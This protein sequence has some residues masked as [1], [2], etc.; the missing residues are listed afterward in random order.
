M[1]IGVASVPLALAALRG[2]AP[3]ARRGT[4]TAAGY[5]FLVLSF[6]AATR[7]E[8]PELGAFG[9][10]GWA[11]I[12][13]IAGLLALL[14][15]ALAF[16]AAGAPARPSPRRWL[17]AAVLVH[18]GRHPRRPGA[19][20][21]G[22]DAPRHP[23]P[24]DA[25]RLRALGASRRIPGPRDLPPAA[26][27]RRRGAAPRPRRLVAA[28]A[29]ARGRGV[30]GHLAPSPAGPGS[31]LDERRRRGAAGR[32]PAGALRPRSRSAGAAGGH[33][34]LG[35]RLS[36]LARR[37]RGAGGAGARVLRD[38]RCRRPAALAASR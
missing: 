2:D 26:A 9:P 33:G 36:D 16:R 18:D 13:D 23:L 29:R 20:V 31:P 1:V 5:L 32:G 37:G 14:V 15:T 11:G 35:P 27:S 17:M 24:A 3:A 22:S 38:L 19:S 21:G 10:E 12:V 4:R 28:R 6:F 8:P 30:P 25:R 34:P 7:V